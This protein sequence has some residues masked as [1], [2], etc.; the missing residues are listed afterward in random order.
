MKSPAE[1]IAKALVRDLPGRTKTSR[2]VNQ[3]IQ[4]RVA[5]RLTDRKR[6]RKVAA[7][8]AATTREQN[9]LAQIAA[10]R[11]ES[12]PQ[13]PLRI[14]SVGEK[15]RRVSESL[16]M[17]VGEYIL[18][19]RSISAGSGHELSWKEIAAQ[20]TRATSI[21]VTTH[22]VRLWS[23]GKTSF[24]K[25]DRWTKRPCENCGNLYTPESGGQRYCSVSCRPA[26]GGADRMVKMSSHLALRWSVLSR[27]QFTCQYC[28][29]R[30]PQTELRVDHVLPRA[31][32]GTDSLANLTTSCYECNAG[33]GDK[34]L[35]A[36]EEGRKLVG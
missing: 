13:E 29:R 9:R 18:A 33:K 19:A 23:T 7:R 20:I 28:G 34:L 5:S 26:L 36:Q 15:H 30:P 3:A 8:K 16:G 31:K 12:L 25:R 11:Q 1:E 10:A 32:G 4:R 21:E 14:A 22:I 24:R 17:N 35:L 27:D 2:R 6:K